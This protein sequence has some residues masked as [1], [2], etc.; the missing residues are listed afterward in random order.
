MVQHRFADV[1]FG[2]KLLSSESKVSR[3]LSNQDFT[4]GSGTFRHLCDELQPFRKEILKDLGPQVKEATSVALGAP[5]QGQKTGVEVASLPGQGRSLLAT[6]HLDRGTV[7]IRERPLAKVLL[8]QRDRRSELHPES[9]LALQLWQAERNGD[10]RIEA[11]R[12]L[13]DHGG[14]DK[15]AEQIRAV[16]AACC[17]LCTDA[18]D[19]SA[20]CESL[21]RWLGCVR[22]NAVAVTALVEA[23]G[24]I[25]QAK[26][27]L[28]LYP[29]LAR[30]VSRP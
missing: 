7:M 9:R 29:E 15:S 23:E 18:S 17:I 30:S 6:R 1:A 28:A 24:E 21:F 4:E 16:L 22:V 3:L 26:V 27:A 14:Q 2:Q 19:P 8:D 11:A 12:D 20:A 10:K 25:E 5:W 13:L